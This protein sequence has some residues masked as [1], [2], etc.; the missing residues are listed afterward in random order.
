MI[1]RWWWKRSV[2]LMMENTLDRRWVDIPAFDN[3]RNFETCH[4]RRWYATR[5]HIQDSW[6]KCWA[7]CRRFDAMKMENFDDTP[8]KEEP[9]NKTKIMVNRIVKSMAIN[10]FPHYCMAATSGT[11]LL[12]DN[13][14]TEKKRTRR[15]KGW[16][17]GGERWQ[18]EEAE[19]HW[20]SNY[21]MCHRTLCWRI[22]L[23]RWMISV[24]R[25]EFGLGRYRWC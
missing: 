5:T 10:S 1:E 20:I 2:S 15:R 3:D 16:G 7:H 19:S 13:K 18:R 22:K 14:H 25:V 17:G 24:H 12:I 4:N 21:L 8:V 9:Q 23:R 11:K 6:V